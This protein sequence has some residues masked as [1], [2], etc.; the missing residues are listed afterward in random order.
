MTQCFTFCEQKEGE[1]KASLPTCQQAG[2]GAKE[3]QAAIDSI[4]KK[5]FQK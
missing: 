3:N 2:G 1:G 5:L 4:S